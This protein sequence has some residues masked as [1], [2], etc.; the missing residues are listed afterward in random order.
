MH[1]IYSFTFIHFPQFTCSGQLYQIFVKPAAYAPS[2]GCKPIQRK[3]RELATD[4]HQFYWQESSVH[5][6]QKTRPIVLAWP[7]AAIVGIWTLLALRRMLFF[8][9]MWE[10]FSF[11]KLWI[12]KRFYF[13]ESQ[14]SQ[15]I[16]ACVFVS[17]SYTQTGRHAWTTHWPECNKPSLI[18]L[19][20]HIEPG[21]P[22]KHRGEMQKST[23]WPV[24]VCFNAFKCEQSIPE[25]LSAL[26]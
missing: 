16:I 12:K 26:K 10:P 23:L 8:S 25:S 24:N 6:I 15:S 5:L 13:T 11:A 1:C 9:G 21:F 19:T 22:S 2:Q 4:K 14:L 7:Q 18:L 3:G 20:Q 17:Y